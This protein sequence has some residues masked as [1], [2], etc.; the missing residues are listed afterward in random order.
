MISRQRKR[1]YNGALVLL[2][3]L[4]L[5]QFFLSIGI[6]T[7][8]YSFVSDAGT[9]A[10]D[11]WTLSDDSKSN[12]D[13]SSIQIQAQVPGD[14]LTDLMNAG[15]IDDPYYNLN[16]LTQQHVWNGPRANKNDTTN[17]I[18][19]NQRTKTWVYSTSVCFAL[20]STTHQHAILIVEGMKMGAAISWNGYLIGTVTDQFL[21]YQFQLPQ[22]QQS[23]DINNCHV[24]QVIFDPTIST[25]GRFAAASGGWD[26]ACYTRTQDARGSRT[27]SFGIVQP[28]YIALVHHA[29]ITYIVPKIYYKQ[30]NASTLEN[31]FTVVTSVH[32][33]VPKGDHLNAT[34]T[35]VQTSDFTKH[36][37]VVDVDLSPGHHVVTLNSTA[38]DVLLWWPNGMGIQQLYTLNIS[39]CNNN[40]PV[41][42]V[43]KRIGFRTLA[44][45]TSNDTGY[46]TEG[47]GQHGMYLRVN[48][49]AVW[50][51]GANFVP[52]DQLEG[53]LSDDAHVRAVVSAANA[54]MNMLRVWG[55]GAVLPQAFY[56]ACD[57]HGILLYHDLMFVEEDNHGA[58]RT[59]T[60]EKEISHIIRSL[61]S[62][63]SIVI[64]SGCNECSDA[65]MEVYESFVMSAVAKEDDTRA[66][67]PSSPSRF[68]W[69]TGVYRW[70]GKPNGNPLKMQTHGDRDIEIHGPYQRGVSDTFPGVNGWSD[71]SSNETLIPPVFYD[72]QNDGPMYNNVFV[73]EFGATTYSSFE[74]MSATLPESSWSLHG[75]T[76]PDSCRHVVGNENACT[77]TN[78]MAE[79][80]YPCDSRIEAY[81]GNV[82]SLMEVGALSFQR[83]LY[84]CMISQTLWMKGYIETLRSSNSYGALIW[85]LNENWPTGGWGCI[86]YGPNRH[87]QNQVV[88]GRWK[89]L[90]YLLKRHL[91]SDV[92]VACGNDDHC[93][94]RNDGLLATDVYVEIESWRM[95]ESKPLRS[96]SFGITFGP[97]RSTSWFDLPIA[98]REES[99]AVLVNVKNGIQGFIET[100]AFLWAPPK[101][102][103]RLSQ[104]VVIT[105][106]IRTSNNGT[107]VYLKL[108]SDFLALYTVLTTASPGHFSKNSFHLRPG[109]RAL[110]SFVPVADHLDYGI[111]V[112]SLRVQHLGAHRE[113][114]VRTSEIKFDES[115]A[116]FS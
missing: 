106:E 54:N 110:V 25:L 37:V 94:A 2:L 16:V 74:S 21:R 111:F 61:A 38:H 88:G 28:I 83:Q 68:G 90:M 18:Q 36:V 41:S 26:W 42:T 12:K 8:S 17:S 89:P 108:Q 62:H 23:S 70:N 92:I 39:L 4:S 96:A 33:F 15:L 67:W 44:L 78:A 84:E 53:R 55:G 20:S 69:K 73:S 31:V 6:S 27:M 100:D 3:R 59:K 81:F 11:N 87:S 77:G 40:I 75:G 98:F 7:N 13:E 60:I 80:N 9:I 115:N 51:R 97:G 22:Q 10:L 107:Q 1:W 64:W 47:S 105:I 50:S 34:Y 57:D 82:T 49:H 112:D 58:I 116:R 65:S 103:N 86:E 93:F 76:A 79:R 91:F 71:W 52:M 101:S 66:I 114:N 14:V 104:V 19:Y 95:N 5:V 48:G 46:V 99:D 109:D 45:V 43:Q 32:L 24:L 72:P 113:V 85:Q 30:S 102:I 35:I 56:E 29:A 63:P